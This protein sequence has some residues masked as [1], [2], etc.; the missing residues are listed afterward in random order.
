MKKLTII[1]PENLEEALADTLKTISEVQGFTFIHVEGHAQQT[2]TDEKTETQEVS[3]RDLVSG[4]SPKVRADLLLQ[5][6][7][8]E[9]V[10]AALRAAN[11]GLT[12]HSFYWVTSIQIA[13]RL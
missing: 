7:H 3:A 2:L 4:Y 6:Q 1:I 13:G 8:V 10:L 12:G 11:M 9:T 5:D